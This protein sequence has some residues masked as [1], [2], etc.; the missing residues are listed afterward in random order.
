M[1]ERKFVLY[2]FM[3]GMLVF[4]TANTIAGK[5][6][7]LTE[8]KGEIFNHPYF[9]T[10]GMFFGEFFCLL[11]YYIY[12]KVSPPSSNSEPLAAKTAP[13]GCLDKMGRFVFMIPSFFD[14][15]A[16]SLMF[17]GLALSAPSVYQ[18]MRGF[19]MVVVALYSIVF[20]K[21]KLFPHQ[22][23][24]VTF[25]F[26]GVILVGLASVLY[27]ASSAK[28]P[29]LG[30]IIIIVAQ[31]FAGGVFVSEQLFL[32]N[33]VIH[34]LQ[35]VGIEGLTGFGY[36]IIVLPIFNLIPCS[37][38]D[39]CGDGYV[40]NSVK[41]FEQIGSSW[42]LAL[43]FLGFMLSISLF[44]FTGVTTTKKAGALA[45]STIDTSRTVLIWVFSIFVG[46]E[47]F[48]WLQLVGFFFLVLGTLVYNEILK[49]PWFGLTESIE[50][51]KIYMKNR[52]EEKHQVKEEEYVGFSPGGVY[53]QTHFK[54]KLRD[55]DDDVEFR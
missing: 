6:M 26:I 17:L 2:L 25:A 16:S 15:C 1:A 41:A 34:P 32:E 12:T 20:L 3:A 55:G 40:E 22:L 48:V 44:N 19:I 54:H 33:I 39:L 35:A 13:K 11:Y 24:G 49:I 9:Q 45:R 29:V 46:W 47:T 27:E 8:S 5:A 31:F 14:F 37:N 10:A 7:D 52:A 28:N 4:G 50:R 23:L 43:L 36:F 30:V 21:V 42:Q 18:M 38:K 51:K 53:D